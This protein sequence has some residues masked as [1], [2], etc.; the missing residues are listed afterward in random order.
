MRLVI[1]QG[2]MQSIVATA[3][4]RHLDRSSRL[5]NVL[6][7]GG[8]DAE[9]DA[10]L[11]EA[12]LVCAAGGRWKSVIDL[13]DQPIE[14]LRLSARASLPPPDQIEE[15][16]CIRNWQPINEAVIGLYPAARKVVY[17]DGMG[18]IDSVGE[19]AWRRIDEIVAPIP[20]LER[21][22]YLG[23]IPVEI[24][25][26]RD[27]ADAIDAALERVPRLAAA[28]AELAR[29]V[30]GGTLVL[31][32]NL[33]EAGVTTLPAELRLLRS[34]VGR[35]PGSSRVVVKPHPRASLGQATRLVRMLRGDGHR[36]T[37]F[38]AELAHYPI[39]LFKQLVAEADRIVAGWSSSA[40][41]LQYLYGRK[42]ET[43]LP[44]RLAL[45][46][47]YPHAVRRVRRSVAYTTNAVE[48][49]SRWRGSGP[50]ASVPIDQPNR[51]TRLIGVLVAGPFWWG[52]VRGQRQPHRSE[53]TLAQAL[54][55]SPERAVVVDPASGT[56]WSVSDHAAE[57]LRLAMPG[58]GDDPAQ[59]VRTF[60][61]LLLAAGHAD[62][63]LA[64]DS[65]L[66]THL[67]LIRRRRLRR[68]LA[69]AS[70]ALT[71]EQV[72]QLL[73]PRFEIAER[74]PEL[75]TGGRRLERTAIVTFKLRPS[76]SG[77]LWNE[78][79]QRT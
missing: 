49:V 71:A 21:R 60:L 40:V 55:P 32:S 76:K 46:T 34:L 8:L 22:P 69:A 57:A 44:A 63:E 65:A 66:P 38:P 19:E 52:V 27:V 77:W 37:V 35:G 24:V 67:P 30:R 18:L 13:A 5:K 29:A 53:A 47:I 42:S 6:V 1:T 15:I 11:R 50:L 43:M 10:P 36:A 9:R 56:A 33:T 48:S 70:T 75:D 59:R 72:E 58:A 28:D 61:D 54:Q 78:P 68:D 3:V 17:G 4:V 25:A 16:V 64:L 14:E 20:Q 2:P 74:D 45:R 62:V 26:R 73:E 23:R 51:I 41:S 7:I 31:G 79:S 12:T 39:E